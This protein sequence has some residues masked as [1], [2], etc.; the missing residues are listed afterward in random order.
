MAKGIRIA[1]T[2]KPSKGQTIT[3]ALALGSSR[4]LCRLK[5]A[6]RYQNQAFR[7]L[8]KHRTTFEQVARRN[9]TSGAKPAPLF[10]Q[11][12]ICSLQRR[13]GGAVEESEKEETDTQAV[14]RC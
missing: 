4:Q 10:Q 13:T 12:I 1:P 5:T 3:F 8:H 9:G 2:S 14:H 11:V 6:F 7:Y